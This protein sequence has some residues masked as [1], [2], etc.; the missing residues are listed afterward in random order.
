MKT[1]I[2]LILLFL[3]SLNT[4]AQDY[5][6]WSLPEGAKMRLGKGRL[7]GNIAYS[8][9]GTRLAVASSIGIWLYDT[10]THQEVALLTGHNLWGW[11]VAFSPD[12]Q[13]IA[14]ASF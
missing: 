5:A 8:P 3:F 7:S 2:T 10:A 14:S 12:G 13:T 9:D 1:I 4:F 11:S 6:Q